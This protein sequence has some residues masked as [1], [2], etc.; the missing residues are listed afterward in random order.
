MSVSPGLVG[1]IIQGGGVAPPSAAAA[2]P[3]TAAAATAPAQPAE[4]KPL[5]SEKWPV[6]VVISEDAPETL[7]VRRK[8]CST[9]EALGTWKAGVKLAAATGRAVRSSCNEPSSWVQVRYGSSSGYVLT[10]P[11]KGSGAAFVQKCA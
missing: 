8:A 10:S 3:Q 4:D 1:R 11:D 6:C 9:A 7:R 5:L 2:A